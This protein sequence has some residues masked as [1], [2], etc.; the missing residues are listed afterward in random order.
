MKRKILF[1]AL[2]FAVVMLLM[3]TTRVSAADQ[4]ITNCSDDME[5][6]DDLAGMQ[7]SGG[8]VLTFNCGTTT[9]KLASQLPDIAADTVIDGGGK[10]TLSGN[11]AVRLFQVG[12]SGKL[13]LKNITLEKGYGKDY[14]GGAI[15]SIGTALTL[16]NT[17]IRYSYTPYSGGAIATYGPL[18]ILNSTLANNIAGYGGA[19][20]AT[21][22]AAAIVVKI[23]NSKFFDNSAGLKKVGGAIMAFAPVDIQDSE[24]ARNSAGSGGAIYAD[25]HSASSIIVNSNFHDNA[26]K[27]IYPTGMGGALLVQA[28]TYVGIQNSVLQTNFGEPGGAIAVLTGGDLIVVNSTLSGNQSS[29]GGGLFNKG[30]TTLS[31]VTVAGN[32]YSSNGGGIHNFGTLTLTNVTLSGNEASNGGGLKNENGTATLTNVTLANNDGPETGGALYNEGT[33]AHLY[34]K[35]VIVANSQGS[36]NCHFLKA[37]ES[38][39]FNLSSDNS[40]NFGAGRDNV[41]LLLGP[42]ANN[43]GSTQT[44]L[45]QSG[46]PAI[47]KGTATDAPSTDQRGV[48]RPQGATFDVG[49]VEVKPATTCTAKPA[50]PTLLKPTNNAHVTNGQVKLD[51]SDV[52]CATKYKVRVKQDSKEGSVVF[53]KTVT[54]SQVTTKALAK[55]HIYFWRVKACN[56]FGC[57]PSVW[58][59]FIKP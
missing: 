33:N 20:Y 37:P 25:A 17:T 49:A 50:A 6:H 41:N 19:I 58:L 38:S 47:D 45:P 35:N 54:L 7:T 29:V 9:I 15:Y 1:T 30:R 4:V 32:K 55:A 27:G 14:S 28:N 12:V 36:G 52:N 31:G 40:C 57:K 16:E 11:N 26:V 24:F 21:E 51:W 53:K 23:R 13:K 56:T 18:E 59:H 8:G 5:L 48:L 22:E 2:V 10:I 39:E 3:P 43:G 34:L 46:S 42:L 44:H